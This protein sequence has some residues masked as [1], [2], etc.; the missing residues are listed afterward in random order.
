MDTLINNFL[1]SYANRFSDYSSYHYN[2]N[3][4][5]YHDICFATA[6]TLTSF[7][8]DEILFSYN[9]DDDDNDNSHDLIL[10]DKIIENL[11]IK[12]TVI[13]LEYLN[14]NESHAICFMDFK[15]INKIV[16]CQSIG[17]LY[18]AWYEFFEISQMVRLLKNFMNNDNPITHMGNTYPISICNVEINTI[19]SPVLYESILPIFTYEE[20][21]LI[22]KQ[23]L[24]WMFECFS[25]YNYDEIMELFSDDNYNNISNMSGKDVLKILKNGTHNYKTIKNVDILEYYINLHDNI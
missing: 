24:L 8:T 19:K 3:I 14:Q 25:S 11:L 12:G 20:E 1:S 10:I 22:K 17:G 2:K 6:E 4:T 18:K 23:R 21:T 9:N 16:V 13:Y 7:L 5:N 15:E